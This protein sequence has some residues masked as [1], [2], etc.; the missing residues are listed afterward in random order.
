MKKL[1]EWNLEPNK[2][3][4][5]YLGYTCEISRHD[6]GH[7]NAYILIPKNHILH[8]IDELD[9]NEILRPKSEIT[10]SQESGIFW[11]VGISFSS[12]KDF[13]PNEPEDG[14]PEFMKQLE[15]F[16]GFKKVG[17]E[18]YKNIEYAIEEIK[19]I[20]SKIEQKGFKH[21]PN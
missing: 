19:N 11:K 9:L 1:S 14:Q 12:I 5:E 6:W 7:L 3:N 13:I 2:M 20:V 15:K 16:F 17:P 8:G 18:A 21:E 10:Y 4:F